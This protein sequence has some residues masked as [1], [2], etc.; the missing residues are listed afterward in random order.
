[1]AGTQKYYDTR[2]LSGTG[3]IRGWDSGIAFLFGRGLDY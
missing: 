3:R 1:M 2:V